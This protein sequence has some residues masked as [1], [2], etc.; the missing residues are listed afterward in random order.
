MP[1]ITKTTSFCNTSQQYIHPV[2][3]PV[4]DTGDLVIMFVSI[5]SGFIDGAITDFTQEIVETQGPELYCYSHVAGATPITETTINSLNNTY[6]A[7]YIAIIKGAPATNFIDSYSLRGNAG[8][9]APIDAPGVTTTTDNCLV[10]SCLGDCGGN[11][12][13]LPEVSSSALGYAN[14]N[15]YHHGSSF[16]ARYQITAG[17]TG[18]FLYYSAAQ[19]NPGAITVA[20]KDDGTSKI[21][22]Y[23][24]INNPAA[25]LLNS[26]N[27]ASFAGI[28]GTDRSV[29][30]TADA[31]GSNLIPDIDG[32]ATHSVEADGQL[33]NSNVRNEQEYGFTGTRLQQQSLSTYNEIPLIGAFTIDS[34]DLTDEIILFRFIIDAGNK[35]PY[36]KGVCS[37]IVSDGNGS[38]LWAANGTEVMPNTVKSYFSH[39]I[40]MP[41]SSNVSTGYELQEY[42][43]FDRS[44]VT[45][46]GVGVRPNS[47]YSGI[48]M[49][50]LYLLRTLT[51]LGGY[52]GGELSF[53]DAYTLAQQNL[54]YT[55]ESQNTQ[56][57]G[58]F[59][60]MQKIR[61]GNGGTDAV[62]WDSTGQSIEFPIAANISELKVQSQINPATLGIEFDFGTG[63]SAIIDA[64]TYNMGDYHVFELTSGDISTNGVLVLN[65]TVVLHPLDN[66]LS[67]LT[68]SACKEITHNSTDMTSGVVISNCVDAQAITVTTETDFEKLH[69]CTFSGNSVAIKITGDQ[70]GTWT[71]PNLTVSG[72]TYDIEYTGTTDFEI[73][74]ATSLSVHDGTNGVPGAGTLTI[75]T[76]TVNTGLSFT[77][78]VAGSQVVIFETGT[79]TEI[80]RNNSTA[81]S[82]SWSEVYSADQDVDYT[83]MKAGYLP[84]RVAGVTAGNSVIPIS[85]SQT[86]DPIY[87]SSHG[88]AY[89]TNITYNRTT[90]VLTLV[91]REEGRSIYSALIAEFIAQSTLANTQF[92][93]KAIGPDRID[94]LDGCTIDD[95][96]HWKGAGMQWENTSDQVIGKWCS[97]K[98]AGT[99]P[100]GGQ[101]EY[102]QVDGST[103]TDLRATGAVDQIFKF[104]EDANGDGTPDYDYSTHLVIEY[105][106][107]GYYE[108]RANVLNGLGLTE[109]E[110]Y[111]YTVGMEPEAMTAAT[112]DPAITLTVVDHTA[113]PKVVGGKSFDYEIQDGGTN[114]AED[115]LRE[116]NYNL[117]QDATYHS[118]NPFNWPD[119][120]IE[121][122]AD[123]AT[124]VGYVDGQDTT[125][126]LHGCY[127]SRGGSDHPDFVRFQSNDESY[128]VEPV[129]ANGSITSLISGSRVRI[130]RN[131]GV[132]NDETINTVVAAAGYSVSYTDGTTY[133]DGDV[134]TITIAYQSGL[135]AKKIQTLTA[136][137]STTGWSAVASQE[138]D[139]VYE[140]NGI[141]GSTVTGY[142]ADYVDDADGLNIDI[143][144]AGATF[145]I[146]NGYAWY[147]HN[148]M[149]EEGIRL[150]FNVMQAINAG[151][152]EF[153]TDIAT[154]KLDNV[155]TQN[156][157]ETSN[158]LLTCKDGSDP[159]RNPPTGGFGISMNV[160]DIYVANIGGSALTAGEK[161][162]L[163]NIEAKSAASQIS[164][165][166]VVAHLVEIKGG[167]FDTLTDSLEQIKDNQSAVS[168]QDKT[169]IITGT[170]TAILG[171][172]SFP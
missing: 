78:L 120:V 6:V 13:P 132:D 61:I 74:S 87:A 42:G 130:V 140:N 65:G 15:N 162:S 111:E 101:G 171:A 137:V 145:N 30:I 136:L 75:V 14:N 3:I 144:I 67:G 149:T 172:E 4:H 110:S 131:V 68:F 60:C 156:L 112:G 133:S 31:T 118:K 57:V 95:L 85:V 165:D 59:Y 155:G 25:I 50:P 92:N 27:T 63:N 160:G 40:Q 151:H 122:G 70:S 53:L 146:L 56:S 100:A 79:Q 24:D 29:N 2:A 117:S 141:A 33:V 147:V 170:K 102:Q 84:I 127:V 142:S 91:T 99:I 46:I 8:N 34:L 20:I 72:N 12:I 88:L 21:A 83:I 5:D 124:S 97:I 134:L 41:D 28:D 18:D 66:I 115:I 109:L 35:L 55:I 113:S 152:Y 81:T 105:H 26:F 119:F 128:Y 82:E 76:P 123:Y 1:Y 45:V 96:D 106:I 49:S 22:A 169:D 163:A 89:T 126:T 58:Q 148:L 153:N 44:A 167:G 98:S 43:T 37:L 103:T 36:N 107:N 52:I 23:K 168:D 77:G 159:R 7:Y 71:D 16:S 19:P 154:V 39:L 143:Q 116:W 94:F 121:E 157:L 73:Q 64:N 104:Y 150:F 93:L 108:S 158:A 38:M 90:K 48:N 125:T 135:N 129:T 62:V 86:L 51:V 11:T 69:N 17:A 10:L 138:T 54:L 9:N 32:N 114:T 139:S 80:Q 166:N 47:S 164:I 161:T